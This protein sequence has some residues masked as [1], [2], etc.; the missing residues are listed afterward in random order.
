M[1]FVHA[2]LPYLWFGMLT[3][4]AGLLWYGLLHAPFLQI[5]RISVSGSCRLTPAEIVQCAGIREGQ[6]ILSFSIREAT[7][8]IERN[9]WISRAVVQR[10]LPDTIEI[11]VEERRVHAKIALDRVYGVDGNGE[12]FAADKAVDEPV[13]LLRGIS[14]ADIASP[15][16]D[17]VAVMQSALQLIGYLQTHRHEHLDGVTITM[18]KVCGLTMHDAASDTE[19]FLGF[20]DFED[21]FSLLRMVQ[22]DLSRK[23]L[24]AAAVYLQS[25]TQAAVTVRDSGRPPASAEKSA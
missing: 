16:P 3:G 18:D 23:N 19:V 12:I 17:C 7:F 21:K 5:A 11:T 10:T 24:R 14:N 25:R 6:N 4:A 13:P 2:V 22:D 9:P 1:R 15:D 8:G 20:G